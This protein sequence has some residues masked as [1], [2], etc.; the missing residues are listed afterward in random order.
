ME[1]QVPHNHPFVRRFLGITH[2]WNVAKTCACEKGNVELDALFLCSLLRTI[3]FLVYAVKE[4][5]TTFYFLL[6]TLLYYKHHGEN[7]IWI[8][9][10][11]CRIGQEKC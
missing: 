6:L 11:S 9:Y 4:T 10:V 5:T 8:R 3:N 7:Q 2:V 1:V